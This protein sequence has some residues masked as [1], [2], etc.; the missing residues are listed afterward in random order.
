MWDNLSDTETIKIS[1]P[2]GKYFIDQR[3]NNKKPNERGA[4]DI[5]EAKTKNIWMGSWKADERILVPKS[6]K[7]S[8]FLQNREGSA[9]HY[10]PGEKVKVFYKWYKCMKAFKI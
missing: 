1:K 6:W 10:P 9:L 5:T 2:K 8:N 3:G 7:M 4:Q